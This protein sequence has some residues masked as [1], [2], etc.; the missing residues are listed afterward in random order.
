MTTSYIGR[1]SLRERITGIRY[2]T[3]EKKS[4]DESPGDEVFKEKYKKDTET[5]IYPKKVFR[6]TN[7][8]INFHHKFTKPQRAY[9]HAAYERNEIPQ[10]DFLYYVMRKTRVP[11]QRPLTKK[12]IQEHF[13]RK[14]Y[15]ESAEVKKVFRERRQKRHLEKRQKRRLEKR[16]KKGI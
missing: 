15:L 5:P 10:V 1:V 13:R 16:Q 12:M 4:D 2:A 6:E 8:I 9:L 14:R 7:P 11:G 3:D